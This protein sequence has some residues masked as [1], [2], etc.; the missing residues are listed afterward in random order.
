MKNR[1]HP[2]TRTPIL[3]VT[4][5]GIAMA[6]IES[7]VVVYLRRVFYPQGFDFPLAALDGNIN[8]I[9]IEVGREAATIVMLTAVGIL[10]GRSRIEKFAYLLYTFGVWDL[11]YYVWLKVFIGWPPS[12]L[13]WDILFLIP[14]PWVG[15]VLAPVLV[16][17]A[18][19]ASALWIIRREQ[20]GAKHHFPLWAWLCEIAAGLIIILAFIWDFKH[21]T[22]GGYP[23][24][25][26]WD[27]FALGWAGGCILF[28]YLMIRSQE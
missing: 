20:R 3:W 13:T 9:L 6:Y 24:A 12:L 7:A 18:M 4:I 2:G 17:I 28:V 27:L 25:F 23:R 1:T 14:L 5:F 16:S 22:A 26:H 19:I 10:I 8:M 11:F 15:P 21:I